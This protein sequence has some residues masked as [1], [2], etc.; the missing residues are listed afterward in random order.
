M[1]AYSSSKA[2]LDMI[3]KCTGLQLAPKGIRVNSVNPGPVNSLIGRGAGMT[4]PAMARQMFEST[5]KNVPLKFLAMGSDIGHAVLFLANN[6]LARNISGTILVSDTGVML[7]P[8]CMKPSL[9][10]REELMK[11]M[12][13]A[14]K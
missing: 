4:D 8:G 3:T 6:K 7:D 13:G 11:K 9:E 5:T 14:Q 2:G 10:E 12:T 1:P